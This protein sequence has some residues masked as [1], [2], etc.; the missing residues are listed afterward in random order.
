MDFEHFERGYLLP[1]GCRDLID[2]INL[3]PEKRNPTIFLKAVSTP[4]GPE[5]Q[6]SG[7]LLVSEPITV[8]ELASL[9][10]QEPFKIIADLMKF[11]FFAT[12]NQC[13]GFEAVSQVARKYGYIAKKWK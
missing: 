10:K 13:L 4:S 11:G 5:P 1:K 7:D 3:F 6:I 12:V 9:L 8:G 2:V